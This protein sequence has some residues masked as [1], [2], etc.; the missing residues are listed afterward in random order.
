LFQWEGRVVERSKPSK[1]LFTGVKPV[2]LKF[3]TLVP[4]YAPLIENVMGRVKVPADEGVKVT[5][6]VSELPGAMVPE[7][8]QE[9]G[10]LAFTPVI[11]RF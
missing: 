6:A 5:M 2:A 4:V 8:P 11:T 10:V 1:K 7:Y 3:I 9:K